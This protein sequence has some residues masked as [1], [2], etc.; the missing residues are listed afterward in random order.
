MADTHGIVYTPQPIVDF[1]CASVEEVLKKE[2][3]LTL[4]HK[5][6]THPRPLHGHRQL[7]R[8]PPPPDSRHRPAAGVRQA[9][10]R[11]RGDA[12]AVL[13]RG[14]EHRARLLRA[15]RRPTIPFEGLCFVDTLDLVHERQPSLFSERNA[16]RIEAEK[17]A[18]VN[19]IIGNP[20]YNVGQINENDNNKN[21][22]YGGK[23][24]I[25]ASVKRTYAKDSKATNKNALSDPYVKFFRWATDRL[26]GRDG[27]VCYVTNNSFVEQIAF[28]GMRKHLLGGFTRVYHLHLEGNVRENPKLAGTAYNVFGIQVGVGITIGVRSSKHTDRK[29]YFHRIDKNL[30]RAKKLDWIA[31]KV[32]LGGVQWEELTPDKHNNWLVPE[33][34]GEFYGFMPVGSKSAKNAKRKKIQAVFE[35][36]SVGVKSNRDEAV[37]GFDRTVLV[38]RVKQF[39]EDYNA[40]VDRYKRSDRSANLDE[41]VHYDKIKWSESLKANLVRGRS[42]AF[43]EAQLRTALFRPFSKRTLCFND[44]L[45]ERRYQFP[46]IFPTVEAEAENRVIVLSDIGYR[47]SGFSALM[48]DQIVDLHLCASVDAHQCFPFY[49]YDEVG[50]NRREN[51]T[52]WALKQFRTRYKDKK[53]TKWD[54][55]HYVYALLHHPGYRTKF[56]DNLKKSLPRIPFAPDFR[57][58]ANAGKELAELHAATRAWSRTR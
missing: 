3:G 55:F 40:E 43:E 42:A 45:V 39:I 14:A 6:V 18:P 30:K 29:V 21:R 35:V 53:L 9:V 4:G 11:Q 2:F 28:D 54:I 44:T 49:V 16:E 24:G 27:I 25:D 8:E 52:D 36:T 20:P 31:A 37:Y 46:R 10:V 12:A 15:D 33:N 47:A 13:H 1:M 22:R 19:V 41:F 56:A 58:F 23:D 34:A 38:N 26:K 48:S 51:I 5:D 17:F 7:H 57:A 50:T 32:R